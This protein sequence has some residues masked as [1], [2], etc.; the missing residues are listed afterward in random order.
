MRLKMETKRSENIRSYDALQIFPSDQTHFTQQIVYCIYCSFSIVV[1]YM[2]MK[3]NVYKNSFIFSY[4]L[5][6]LL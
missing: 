2:Y 5:V 6:C 3:N 1:N 4:G